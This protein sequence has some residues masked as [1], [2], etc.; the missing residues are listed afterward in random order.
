MKIYSK[1]GLF[2]K[3]NKRNLKSS[4]KSFGIVFFIF[5]FII[6]FWNFRGEISQV[7]I[8]PFFLSFIFLFLGLI[9]SKLLTPLNKIWLKLGEFLGKIVAPIVMGIVYFLVLTPIGLLMK[10]L[11]KDLLQIKFSKQKSY[12][13]KREKNIGT[14]KRQF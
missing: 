2:K 3:M 5:F 10:A 7:K 14:M 9:N 4:N 8:F 1:I 6:A 11:G 12:W 13:L